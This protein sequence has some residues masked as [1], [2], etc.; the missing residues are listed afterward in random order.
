MLHSMYFHKRHRD[1]F[2]D[3]P[4]IEDEIEPALRHDNII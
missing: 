2:R 4:T 3:H 1:Y